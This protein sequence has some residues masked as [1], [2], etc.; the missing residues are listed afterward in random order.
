METSGKALVASG[1]APKRII[2]TFCNL[3]CDKETK[4]KLWPPNN[5]PTLRPKKYSNFSQFRLFLFVGPAKPLWSLAP[6]SIAPNYGLQ[7][8]VFSVNL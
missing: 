8:Q 3:L 6:A 4:L 1:I 5:F 2:F 7:I